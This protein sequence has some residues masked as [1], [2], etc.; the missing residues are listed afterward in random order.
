MEKILAVLPARLKMWTPCADDWRH[1]PQ[2]CELCCTVL[3]SCVKTTRERCLRCAK[4]LGILPIKFPLLSDRPDE[5]TLAVL[6]AKMLRAKMLRS[7]VAVECSVR[8]RTLSTGV[9]CTS[10]ISAVKSS[11]PHAT[12]KFEIPSVFHFAYFC[13]ASIF[14]VSLSSRYCFVI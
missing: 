8:S 1:P 12:G 10:W 14:R 9:A 13:S 6:R 2:K 3:A 11:R 4:K 7:D 5:L